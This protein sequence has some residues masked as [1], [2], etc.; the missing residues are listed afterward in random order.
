MKRVASS[1][2]SN[3]ICISKI[4]LWSYYDDIDAKHSVLSHHFIV[5]LY[6]VPSLLSSSEWIE[7]KWLLDGRFQVQIL[8]CLD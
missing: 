1:N 3:H 5:K 4:V 2:G 7:T 6:L 8:C